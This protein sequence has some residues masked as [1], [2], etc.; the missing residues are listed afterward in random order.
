MI[1]QNVLTINK[2]DNNKFVIVNVFPIVYSTSSNI[3]EPFRCNSI[4]D[5]WTNL[6]ISMLNNKYEIPSIKG[7][8]LVQYNNIAFLF[9]TCSSIVD[10]AN[11][12]DIINNSNYFVYQNLSLQCNDEEKL[13]MLQDTYKFPLGTYSII[14]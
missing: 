3:K 5:V 14:K 13:I 9:I 1:P 10:N 2:N 8:N 4:G 12:D 7:N 6:H 11:Y